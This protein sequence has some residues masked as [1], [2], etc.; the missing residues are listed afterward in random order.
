MRAVVLLMLSSAA[1]ALAGPMFFAGRYE[2]GETPKF[3]ADAAVV[4]PA[5]HVRYSESRVEVVDGRAVSRTEER[6]SAVKPGARTVGIVPLPVGVGAHE[7]A[8]TID[9]RAAGGRYLA[10]AD[11]G[12]A[13][14]ALAEGTGSGRI[15]ALVGRPAW[16]LPSVKLGARSEVVVELQQGLGAEGGLRTLELPMPA[17]E[18]TASPVRRVRVALSLQETAPIRAVFSPS[19]EIEVSRPS[20]RAASVR[21]A[22]ERLGH[23][24]P[25]RLFW[26]ADTDDLG[27]RIL[28]HRG[29][30][31]DVGYFLLLGNPTG[32]A[33]GDAPVAKD[34]V[35]VVD[36]S[37]SM[38]GEKMEQARS[39]IEYVLGHLGRDD[40]FN[41]V[42][43]GTDVT[44]FSEGLTANTAQSRASAQTFV[45]DL[46]AHGRTNISGA[47]HAGLAGV[48]SD[49][50]RIMLFLT[51]GTPTAG[52]RDPKRIV[53]MLPAT[54]TS[55]TQVFV[56]GVGHDVNA[57]LLDQIADQTKGASAYVEPDEE[58]DVKV[59]SLYD[60]LSHPVL[61]NVEVAFGGLQAEHVYPPQMPALFRGREILLLG[62]YRGHG[63][64]TFA[65]TGQLRS[66]PRLYEA[67]ADF[68]GAA[69][70]SNDFV[71]LLWASRR[72]GELLREIRLAGGDADK[73]GE[74]V[75]LSRRFGILTE[76]TEFMS[77]AGKT[78]TF[79]E[80]RTLATANVQAARSQQAGRWAVRQSAN[81]AT[82]RT[83]KVASGAFNTY[84]DRKGRTKAAAKLKSVGRRAF[85]KRDGKWVQADDGK[86]RKKRRVK[87]FSRE[88]MDLVEQ[89]KDFA[90]A[91]RLDGDML[92]NVGDE[93]VEVY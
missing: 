92:I 81:E 14:G 1:P 3:V 69:Q 4:G 20:L 60:S 21:V 54:N 75:E 31:E 65:L 32:S 26:A 42:A 62:R 71:A 49:R 79:D 27:L 50:P 72:I 70:P 37:G 28:T 84:R 15:L 2:A 64:H 30:E 67:S 18:F 66:E 6:V 23:G 91:Q 83:K 36:T 9:G 44:S 86:D 47:L 17:A 68:P 38:R 76:Y 7:V 35:L 43:F 16:L 87:R 39:A 48:A 85:Y 34:V 88:Y 89:N 77:E 61:T 80:A 59:A 24:D 90:K 45:E 56:F 82:L 40:R 57:H 41:V 19:H 13:Y 63:P 52:E 33:A 12:K 10:A 53:S 78:Y 5:F 73:V 46:V 22:M 8:V 51:D 58:I 93:Q 74:V 25:L 11:A 29:E 55:G